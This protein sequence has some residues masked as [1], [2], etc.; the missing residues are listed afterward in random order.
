LLGDPGQQLGAKKN[1]PAADAVS[2][3]GTRPRPGLY[4]VLVLKEQG[5][6]AREVE[7]IAH[8]LASAPR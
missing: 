1:V 7:R 2:G 3:D 4:C 6:G 5:G 8:D